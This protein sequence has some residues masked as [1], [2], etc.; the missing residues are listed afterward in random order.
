MS[1]RCGLRS[2]EPRPKLEKPLLSDS[3]LREVKLL[4]VGSSNGFRALVPC[5]WL[6]DPVRE[7]E[8]SE[9]EF[10]PNCVVFWSCA[11]ERFLAGDT[12]GFLM[13]ALFPQGDWVVWR[14]RLL[15]SD[16]EDETRELK[17]VLPSAMSAAA[18]G[19]ALLSL[20]REPSRGVEPKPD[21][22]GFEF[23]MLLP[24]V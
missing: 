13:W 3:M 7:T 18:P 22:A 20:V 8:K 19:R 6:T 24:H 5:P 23:Q 21:R 11:T 16:S 10:S 15:Q 4:E 17:P 14:G 1:A 2:A 12:P 9:D